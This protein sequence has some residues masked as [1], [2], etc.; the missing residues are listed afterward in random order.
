MTEEMV[1]YYALRARE[2][3]RVYTMERWRAD[4]GVL[5][6]RVAT[7]FAG[8]RVFEVACGTGYWTERLAAV[9]LAVEASDTNEETLA[10]AR[11]RPG[12]SDRVRLVRRDAYAP[13][14]GAPAFDAGFAGLWLSHV[15][16]ARMTEFL[17]AF[18]SHLLP[19]APVL[20]FDEREAPAR[21]V[22]TSR[23]DAAG[24]RYEPRRLATG[25]RFEI[26]KNF[27]GADELRGLLAPYGRDVVFEVLE[28]F[29][30][31][32]YTTSARGG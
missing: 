5:H 32:S 25:D 20:I 27:F 11:A 22:P 15:D 7:R 29:W 19:G 18:H 6:P 3:D 14:A 13:S 26:V 28:A 16:R 23:T 4:L 31:V 2:Y 21:T 17:D 1:R 8:R 9:A 30:V 10:V 12:I 24:N